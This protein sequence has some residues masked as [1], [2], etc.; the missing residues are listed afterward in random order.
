MEKELKIKTKIKTKI[1][2]IKRN[3]LCD[4]NLK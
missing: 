4:K 2:R 1:K 3:I